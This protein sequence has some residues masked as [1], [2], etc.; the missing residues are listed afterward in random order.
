MMSFG[1]EERADNV[2]LIAGNN[3]FQLWSKR[4]GR[5]RTFKLFREDQL[6][7]LH[8]ENKKTG[9]RILDFD[10]SKLEVEYDYDTDKE[11]I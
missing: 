10:M 2:Q 8:K 4:T 5:K 1:A 6:P 3:K 7:F 9:G 11:Q